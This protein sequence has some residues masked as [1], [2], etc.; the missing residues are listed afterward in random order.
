MLKQYRVLLI[1]GDCDGA[2]VSDAGLTVGN[3][4]LGL[5]TP[6]T[7]GEV[8]LREDLGRDN[9]AE[10]ST[11]A[12]LDSG[13][14]VRRGEVGIEV[15]PQSRR[16]GQAAVGKRRPALADLALSWPCM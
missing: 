14:I 8:A 16:I 9:D 13:L 11:V 2:D 15:G 5:E 4:A 12:W 7:L 1:D 3:I 10:E 6:Q